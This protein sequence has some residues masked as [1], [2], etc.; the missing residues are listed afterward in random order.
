M[1][2]AHNVYLYIGGT[3]VV[4][5]VEI[6]SNSVFEVFTIEVVDMALKPLHKSMFCLSNILD[7]ACFASDAVY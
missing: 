7:F 4:L 1:D 5:L 3:M 6:M 2:E